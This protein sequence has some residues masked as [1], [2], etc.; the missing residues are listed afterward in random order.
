MFEAV[1]DPYT[2]YLDTS[3]YEEMVMS[4]RGSYG[5]IGIIVTA[6]DDGY[7][8]VISPIEGTPGER[9]GLGT[10]DRIIRVDHQPVTGGRLDDAVSLM[11]G[12]P[13][14]E[15]VVEVLKR[16]GRE[17]VE[18]V[19]IREN[20]RIE[21][22]RSEVLENETGYIRI[23][24]F[25]EQTARD[26]KQHMDELLD[27]G[28][29]NLVL[30]MRNN[31]GGLLNQAIRIADMLLGEGLIVYTEDRHGNRREEQSDSKM[32]EMPLVVLMNEGSASAS[33]IL[34][35]AIQDHE[36]GTIV[37]VTSFGK[38]LVQE[39][40]RLPDGTGFKYTVSQYFTPEGRNIHDLGIVPD[41]IVEL[42]D[43]TEQP[44]DGMENKDDIQLLK[45]LELLQ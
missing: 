1:G 14:T 38:G 17:P 42:P 4:T 19:I 22:V 37:G 36:R 10:G 15:V 44:I 34:A 2:T 8:S 24:S 5:G 3:D 25:D 16:N 40:Q 12:E 13:D 39:L 27:Q 28:V 43:E 23:T 18:L 20:I 33:E 31:P 26:F 21:S 7:V 6:D 30:D 11:R 45:A 35:G 41:V 32:Y 29:R 9:A